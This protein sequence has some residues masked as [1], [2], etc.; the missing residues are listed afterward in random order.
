MITEQNH[1][2][3]VSVL[4]SAYN[5]EKYILECIDSIINQTYKNIE[6][7]VIDDGSTDNTLRILKSFNDNRL[8]IFSQ[9]NKGRVFSR[10]RALS[11]ATGKYVI[12]Q[13]ADDWSD[14]RRIELQLK[15][16]EEL[17]GNPVVGCNYVIIKNNSQMIKRYPEEDIDI[18]K[19]MS[20]LFFSQAFLP[21]SILLLRTH[22][23]ALKGWR[24]KFDIACEDGDLLDR[25]FEDNS[26]V[27]HNIQ[28]GLYYYRIHE[29]SVTNKM[30]LTIPYQIF[31][32]DCKLRRRS[33][34]NE[35]E[36]LQ[37]YLMFV[38]KNIFR[39]LLYKLSY[40]SFILAKRIKNTN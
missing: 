21:A 8:K 7:I 19:R 17:C 16:A 18:R 34:M 33:Q 14:K 13:D 40:F 20:R 22:L 4:I 35:F 15:T 30:D 6:I 26:S 5:E 28:H 31:K 1:T 37:D 25:I 10:N 23:I 39:R 12:L 36:D 9:K 27:F 2:P 24:D 32:R 11:L 29:G 3:K 38:S